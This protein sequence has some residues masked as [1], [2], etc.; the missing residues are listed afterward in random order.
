M[1]C[2]GYILEF[3]GREEELCESENEPLSLSSFP[4]SYLLQ[5]RS[6]RAARKDDA[7]ARTIGLKLELSPSPLEE[8]L[9]VS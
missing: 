4:P 9:R 7:V 6:A 3:I 2:E 8:T 5:I 1:T